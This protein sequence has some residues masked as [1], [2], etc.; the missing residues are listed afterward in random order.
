LKWISL[1]GA[2]ACGLAIIA[3]VLVKIEKIPYTIVGLIFVSA[4]IFI[5]R[6]Y[7]LKKMK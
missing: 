2:I 5:L 1:L 3:D 4:S 6:P 7:I